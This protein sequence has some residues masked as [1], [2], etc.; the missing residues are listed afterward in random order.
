MH[1][2]SPRRAITLG[3]AIL[4]VAT[5][6]GCKDDSTSPGAAG[7]QIVD[8]VTLSTTLVE[9]GRVC[10]GVTA[11]R[12]VTI[13]ANASNT[14]DVTG[15][16]VS[17]ATGKISVTA[18]AGTYT[19]APGESHEFTLKFSPQAPGGYEV[20]IPV[21]VGD[22]AVGAC[23]SIGPYGYIRFEARNQSFTKLTNMSS[24][25]ALTLESG[26][27]YAS[28]SWSSC[29]SDAWLMNGNGI[30]ESVVEITF[31]APSGTNQLY[32]NL[33]ADAE[34]TCVQLLIELDGS[35]HRIEGI[36]GGC[37]HLEYTKG[38]GS[39]SHTLRIGTDQQGLCTDDL[40][41]DWIYVEL[42][43]TWCP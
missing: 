25:P 5:A 8:G 2:L 35:E 31:N 14:A 42:R 3:A 39:G 21:G 43:G 10:E 34:D 33:Y 7:T 26:V 38:I 12:N 17:P 23:G 30:T 9:F 18:G 11:S 29:N 20:T 6:T 13:T 27:S 24:P 32:V 36:S 1:L 15:E 40:A 41:I 16:I 19:L 22:A 4:A 37:K 28:P